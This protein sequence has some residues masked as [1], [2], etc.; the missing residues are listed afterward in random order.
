MA[1][2]K[3]ELEIAAHTAW[4]T[5]NDPQHHNTVDMRFTEEFLEA[6]RACEAATD[7]RVLVLRAR[8]ECFSFGGDIAEFVREKSRIQQ[9]VR[10]MAANFHQAILLLHRLPAPLLVSVQGMAAG[11]GF[12]L[13]CAADL[14]VAA[15]SARFNFAYTRSG[16]TPDGGSTF[17][18]TRAVGRQKAFELMALNPTLSA[19]EA[20]DL[21]LLAKVVADDAL[22]AETEKMVEQLCRLPSRSLAGLKRLLN[23]AHRSSLEEQ[24]EREAQSIA[25]IAATSATMAT[26][27]AFLQ[28]GR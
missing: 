26:L 14:A 15:Q 2:G 28:R 11:G 1:A 8:G 6:A 24:F 7:L 21:G 23:D 12:S 9:H 18:L 5:L 22:D 16:L 13:V 17:F 25:E 20:A 4:I 3:V 10:I 19:A 27:E